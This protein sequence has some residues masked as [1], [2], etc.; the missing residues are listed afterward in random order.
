MKLGL[1]LGGGGARGFAHIGVLE[2]LERENIPVSLI[3]G[4]SMGSL[5][6]ALYSI[7]GSAQ[8]A[9]DALRLAVQ[10]KCV[11]DIEAMY[12]SDARKQR[13]MA[14]PLRR[15]VQ[16]FKELYV[17]NMR[18]FKKHFVDT[19]PFTQLFSDL[20][21]ERTFSD[22][23]IPLQVVAV[24]LIK[25][26][27]AYLSSGEL[28]RAVQASTSIPGVFAPVAI[29]DM[30]LVDGGALEPVPIRPLRHKSNFVLGINLEPKVRVRRLKNGMDI[31]VSCEDI[32]LNRLVNDA[33]QQADFIIEPD[34]ADFSWAAFS[35]IDEIVARGR[36][37]AERKVDELR[38]VL[39]RKKLVPYVPVP[40]AIKPVEN[41]IIYDDDDDARADTI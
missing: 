5:V 28:R 41:V 34:V 23:S 18:V 33:M 38:K 36:E 13:E 10:T 40:F 7:H 3:A 8:A 35:R 11:R 15:T 24:D 31:M 39:W 25:G 27:A 16:M 1:A 14:K 12:L 4:T 29:G 30:L 37:E 22:G 26:E 9:H 32:R 20:L 19:Q 2:V 17:W 21:G 6:G